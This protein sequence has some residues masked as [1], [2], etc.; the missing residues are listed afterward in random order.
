MVLDLDLFRVDKGGDPALIRETQEKRFKDPRLVDQL[1]KAD[2]EWRRCRF[3]ADN[4]NKLKNLCSKTIGE[5]MKKK[6]PVGDDESIPDNV[7]SLD[8]LTAETLAN[9]KVSQIKKLRLL[10]DDAILK[11]DTDLL[12]LETERSRAAKRKGQ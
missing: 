12:K 11:C 10:I 5:K 1:V 4:L 6:E 3:R 2:G 9:L 7:L 8:D